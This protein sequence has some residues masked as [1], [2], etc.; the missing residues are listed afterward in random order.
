MNHIELCSNFLQLRRQTQA[1]YSC[2]VAGVSEEEEEKDRTVTIR[3]Q[4]P[5]Q[6]QIHNFDPV[7]KQFVMKSAHGNT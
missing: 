6:L 1:T 2:H 3:C 5:K 4:A 7:S